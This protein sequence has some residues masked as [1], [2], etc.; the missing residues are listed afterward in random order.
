MKRALVLLGMAALASVA[1]S[2]ERFASRVVDSHGL[3]LSP[4]YNDPAAALG[5]PTT[6][7]RDTQY[8][9]PDARIAASLAY[10]P[11]NVAPDG[12]NLVVTIPNGGAVTVEFEP[13]LRE[14]PRRWYGKEFIVF[15]NA[16]F[17]AG[18]ITWDTDMGSRAFGGNPGVFAEPITVS[19]S[20]DG[21]TWYT[22]AQ[23]T[24]DG[25]WPTQAFLWQIGAWGAESDWTKPTPPALV[26]RDLAGKTVAQAITLLEGSAG[27]TAFDLADSG[28]THVR[29]L[30]FTGAGGEVDAVSRVSRAPF[31]MGDVNQD[32]FVDL[33][34]Y[35]D[36]AD[37]FRSGPEDPHWNPLADLDDSGFVDLDDYFLLAENFRT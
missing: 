17:G 1:V 28:F 29:Y 31:K 10:A 26:P 9:G 5:K 21:L 25:L 3:G 37:A 34:D 15:G 33:D 23:P 18:Q 4:L 32:G 14:D 27:G 11:W 12:S 13:P 16:F 19:V 7:V 6:W 24:A 30:R 35:F 2:D 8:G 22:Y 36:L 20:P